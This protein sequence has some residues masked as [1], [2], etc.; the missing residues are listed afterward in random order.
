MRKR[1]G[2]GKGM[3]VSQNVRPGSGYAN[4]RV[5]CS[6]VPLWF[7]RMLTCTVIS[8]SWETRTSTRKNHTIVSEPKHVRQRSMSTTLVENAK[9][10]SRWKV[11]D[12][13]IS[14]GRTI[15]TDEFIDDLRRR[16][17]NG[18]L[19]HA[20]AKGAGDQRRL[21]EEIQLGASTRG[22]FTVVEILLA[23]FG[24]PR[25]HKT[26]VVQH[27]QRSGWGLPLTTPIPTGTIEIEPL[28]GLDHSV[29]HRRTSRY[30]SEDS[31]E[32][33]LQTG[34]ISRDVTNPRILHVGQSF[35]GHS[36]G[37]GSLFVSKRKNTSA[38]AAV[39]EAGMLVP[40]SGPKALESGIRIWPFRQCHLPKTGGPR[41][42]RI[43]LPIFARIR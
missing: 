33:E 32:A 29:E 6:V 15:C 13:R 2:T 21:G 14:T 43:R 18:I 36:Q 4:R 16:H 22:R 10:I 3:C 26:G 5:F 11:F 38:M 17:V 34:G 39:Y 24:H 20:F 28:L 12:T 37:A 23:S 30:V 42:A 40:T 27:G 7:L 19:V 8:R 25:R 9:L 35:D 1:T 31:A 41:Q